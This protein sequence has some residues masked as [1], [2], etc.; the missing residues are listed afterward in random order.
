[1]PKKI[2]WILGAA[3]ILGGA[4]WFW[5]R[6]RGAEQGA[7]SEPLKKGT[8]LESVYGI[9]TVTATKSYQLRFGVTSTIRRIYVREGDPV[10]RGDA[11]VESD[12]GVTFSAPF[13]GTVTYLPVKV[14]ETV[15]PQ[16]IIL[17]LVDL[18]D[19]YVVVSLEQ[20]G[21][22]RVRQNQKAR[23]SFDSMRGEAFD[24]TVQA[25]YSNDNNFLVRIGVADLPP[26]V[27]PGMTADVAIAIAEK[28]GVLLA[29]LS[30]IEDG[31]VL[32]KRSLGK[33]KAVAVQTGIVDGAMA[34]IASGEV[35]EGDQ[36]YVKK[37]GARP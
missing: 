19:R 8:V 36:L 15:F 27:L 16:S 14:G 17:N 1:M 24:G 10:K 29:P 33:P 23:I 30:A 34:E 3:L 11:L 18:R 4:A 2:F 13:E 6:D 35:S 12:G 25:L 9:G 32:V 21:A 31:K 20:R 5:F 22:L 37:P 7:Y 28:A 26:Q